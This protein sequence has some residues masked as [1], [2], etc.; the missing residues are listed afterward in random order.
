MSNIETVRHS[1]AHVL[2]AAVQRLYPD[3]KF[4]IGP[5]I[6]DGFYYD[7]DFSEPLNEESLKAIQSEMKKITKQGLDIER[8]E[9]SREAALEFFKDQPYKVE[10]INGLPEGEIISVYKLG[11]FTDLCMGPHVENTKHLRQRAYKLSSVAGAYW[12]G[13][14]DNP[15]MQRIYAW[16]FMEKPELKDYIARREEAMKRDHRRLGEELELFTVSELVGKGLPLFLPKGATIRRILE[17]FIV[18]EEVSRGYLH[19]YS[20]DLGHKSLY[21]ASGHWQHYKDSMYPPMDLE[22]QEYVLRPMTCPHHFMMYKSKLRSYRDLPMRY[23]E[24]ATQFRREL[25]G[26]LTGLIRV[27]SFHLADSHIICRMDQMEEEFSAAVEL[28][29]Y[30]M[31]ALGIRDVVSFRASLRDDEKGK[32]VDDDALWEKAESMFLGALDKL[33]LEYEIGRG[34]AAFYGPKLDIQ[35][36]NVMGK[37]DTIITIQIDFVL[38]ARFDISYTASDG[39]KE[40]PVT[41]HRSSIGC[42]ERTMA[43][44]IE[45]YGGAFPSWFAPVQVRVLTLVDAV[46]DYAKDVIV[47]LRKAGLRV[48]E[49]LRNESIGKKIREG[50]LMRIPYL[51]IIGNSEMEAGTIAVRNRDTGEQTTLSLDDFIAGATGEVDD[52]SLKLSAGDVA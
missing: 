36:R 13:S 40:R 11:D 15:M 24:L 23:A 8:S 42:I 48:E 25:S 22:G 38:P 10:L 44:L 19:V 45:H 17:R 26:T 14:S 20:P 4:G 37:E 41:I 7:F 32:Y 29:D 21:E 51:V 31:R 2:A 46:D 27:M 34:E 3:V 9:L 50:R 30:V 5:A 12:R 47:K 33:D 49:D 1:L 39:T 43:F 28:A 52:F 35:A 6:D 16:A 18:D